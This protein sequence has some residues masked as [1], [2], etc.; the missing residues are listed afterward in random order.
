MVSKTE[1]LAEFKRRLLLA[2]PASSFDEARRQIEDTL[3][4]VEDELSGVPF[5]P[6]AWLSD[7]RMYPPQ[8][9]HA[10]RLSSN[11][12][13]VRFRSREHYTLIARNGAIRIETVLGKEVIL[14]KPGADGRAV[15]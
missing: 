1:R 9:D 13:T 4:A 12:D 2:S 5:D 11:P 14:E 8:D 3:N 6:D 15:F 7:G 10:T